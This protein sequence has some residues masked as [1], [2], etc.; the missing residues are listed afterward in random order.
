MSKLS[1]EHIGAKVRICVFFANTF[2]NILQ[3]NLFSRGIYFREGE[4]FAKMKSREYF[5]TDI[6]YIVFAKPSSA[7]CRKMSMTIKMRK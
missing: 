3:I 2:H 5:H 1:K 6:L 7:I 4:K